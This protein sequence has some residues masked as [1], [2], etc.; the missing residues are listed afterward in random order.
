M[1][2][3]RSE[4]QLRRLVRFNSWNNLLPLGAI[5]PSCRIVP[6]KTNLHK[7]GPRCSWFDP[8]GGEF[9]RG[10]RTFA[11]DAKPVASQ[12]RLELPLPDAQCTFAF[13]PVLL[14]PT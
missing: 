7:P 1:F 4:R 11:S 5:R 8:F 9:I 3:L 14:V 2:A 13:D 6:T 10:V 12:P